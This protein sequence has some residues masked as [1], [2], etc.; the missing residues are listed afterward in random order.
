MTIN[1]DVIVIGAGLGGLSAATMPAHTGLRESDRQHG[2]VHSCV[3]Y[4]LE[5]LRIRL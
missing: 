2:Y 3:A 5:D 1:F 4:P